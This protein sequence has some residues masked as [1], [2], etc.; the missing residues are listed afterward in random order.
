M[1]PVKAGAGVSTATA[2]PR[3]AESRLPVMA[4]HELAT[5]AAKYGA[6]SIPGGRATVRWRIEAASS[7]GDV[8]AFEWRERGG[9]PVSPPPERRGYGSILIE[10]ILVYDLGGSAE[11]TS[12]RR[13]WSVRSGRSWESGVYPGARAAPV[14]RSAIETPS[15]SPKPAIPID[16]GRI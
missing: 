12:R 16:I 1:T 3:A 9:P 11:W 4:L 2:I 7:R 8:L 13:T 5:N 6:L 14:G 10:Q 15:R